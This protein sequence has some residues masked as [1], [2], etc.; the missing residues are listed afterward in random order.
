[1]HILRIMDANTPVSHN[2]LQDTTIIDSFLQARK[3]HLGCATSCAGGACRLGA[4]DHGGLAQATGNC[5]IWL[6]RLL[7]LSARCC[8]RLFRLLLL[9]RLAQAT[10]NIHRGV[11]GCLHTVSICAKYMYTTQ[12]V[13]AVHNSE[14][15]HLV[16][17][18][19]SEQTHGLIQNCERQFD[20]TGL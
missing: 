17:L 12:A 15:V 4:D 20:N 5:V 7:W 13:G 16:F 8:F 9:F 1:M 19:L 18:I 2:W 6:F 11:L 14:Y 10:L 3:S